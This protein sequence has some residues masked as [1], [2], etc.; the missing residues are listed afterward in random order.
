MEGCF[1]RHRTSIFF[2][3]N[4]LSRFLKIRE[5]GLYTF[6]LEGDIARDSIGNHLAFHNEGAGSAFVQLDCFTGDDA[7]CA[8]LPF[9]V[10]VFMMFG[11]M[12]GTG[13]V[14]RGVQ[15]NWAWEMT[16][17]VSVVSSLVRQWM[18]ISVSLQRSGLRLQQT[19]DSRSCSPLRSSTSLSW[20]TGSSPC[21]RLL[22]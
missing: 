8:V 5:G 21:S 6:F 12:A 19:A 14:P 16:S 20:R 18:H 17:F 1:F 22:S 7:P 2:N 10:V 3:F 15:K 9:I 11:I 13:Q 4:L